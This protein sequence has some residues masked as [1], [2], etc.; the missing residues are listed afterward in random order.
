MF[1]QEMA[2][3]D[4]GQSI[5]V[6]VAEGDSHVGFGEA[7]TVDRQAERIGDVFKRAVTA[8]SPKSIAFCIV[9]NEPVEPAVTI[10]V[11]REDSH[12]AAR[13]GHAGRFS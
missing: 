4:I 12:A 1:A 8:V 9:G 3:R 2:D 10:E 6:G 11:G 5:A 13:P 7:L